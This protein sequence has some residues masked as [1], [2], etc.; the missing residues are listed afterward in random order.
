MNTVETA[1][2]SEVLIFV[3]AELRKKWG[4]LKQMVRYNILQI[5]VQVKKT[6]QIENMSQVWMN[7]SLFLFNNVVI[8][9][10]IVWDNKG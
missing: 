7:V 8:L 6:G 10:F 4:W 1:R 3:G 5:Y 9:T 2:V